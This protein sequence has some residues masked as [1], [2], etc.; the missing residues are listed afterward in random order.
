MTTRIQTDQACEH[1]VVDAA[2]IEKARVITIAPDRNGMT[3]GFEG[4]TE[5]LIIDF[6]KGVFSVYR[7]RGDNSELVCHIGCI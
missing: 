6:S 2:D 7:Y 1:A 3:I 5:E 4:E